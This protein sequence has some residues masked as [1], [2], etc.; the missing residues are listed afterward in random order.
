MFEIKKIEE[1]K[2]QELP[3]FPV[4]DE[5]SNYLYNYED[6]DIGSC[7]STLGVLSIIGDGIFRMGDSSM[8]VIVKDTGARGDSGIHGMKAYAEDFCKIA[9]E[10]IPQMSED[11]KA[12]FEFMVSD[13]EENGI[14]MPMHGIL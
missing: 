10:A 4:Q 9:K 5:E 8:A 13:F 3:I 14:S 1:Q 11:Y 12:F 7:V 2:I 6:S